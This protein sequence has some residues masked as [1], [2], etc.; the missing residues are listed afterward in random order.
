MTVLVF[1]M[2]RVLIVIAVF[3]IAATF[4]YW[5][6]RRTYPTVESAGVTSSKSVE[7]VLP[8]I[9]DTPDKPISFGYKTC[10]IAIP[11]SNAEEVLQ[12]LAIDHLQKVNWR[13]GIPA[14]HNGFTFISSPIEGWTFVVSEQLPSLGYNPDT[15][16]WLSLMRSLSEKFG[17]AQYFGSHRIVGFF[18]WA[19]FAN[20][21]EERAFAYLG[22]SGETLVDRG[23]KTA[24]ELE[25]GY[26]Y[27]DSNS[28]DA[29]DDGYWERDDLC[30]PD[31]D[32]VLEIAGKWSI[33]PSEIENKDQ[34]LAVGWIGNLHRMKASR[35]R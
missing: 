14:A 22:E 30:Y 26:N 4:I 1:R 24:G 8:M 2:D 7:P 18:A 34:P 21:T 16:E 6:S 23:P 35:S 9:D 20:G 25:L 27:F 3:V 15:E 10:W 33:N 5:R 11:S 12:S 28:P 17:A 31:E 29:K 13:T 32:H 19:R